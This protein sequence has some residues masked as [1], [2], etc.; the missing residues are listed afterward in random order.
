MFEYVVGIFNSPQNNMKLI[1]RSTAKVS[2][3]VRCLV[4]V[5]MYVNNPGKLFIKIIRNNYITKNEFP[6]SNFTVKLRVFI[7]QVV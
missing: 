5:K 7:L 3:S 4:L 2:V 6:L 1:H